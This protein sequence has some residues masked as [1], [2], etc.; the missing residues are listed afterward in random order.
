MAKIEGY[1][2]LS[3]VIYLLAG[4]LAV[5]LVDAMAVQMVGQKAE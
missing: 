1:R 3:I 2:D 5:V 4:E